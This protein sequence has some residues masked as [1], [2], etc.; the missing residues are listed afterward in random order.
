MINDPFMKMFQHTEF[1]L[2]KWKIYAVSFPTSQKVSKSHLSLKNNIYQQKSAPETLVQET[3]Y[4]K[5]FVRNG[6]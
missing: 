5:K 1:S 4:W 3:F 2:E 6:P